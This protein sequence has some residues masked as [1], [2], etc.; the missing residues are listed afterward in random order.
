MSRTTALMLMLILAAGMNPVDAQG[1]GDWGMAAIHPQ[2]ERFELEYVNP[3][4]HKW[5]G[6]RHLLETHVEPWHAVHT[7]YATEL[8]TRYVDRLLEGEM[9]Y[10]TFGNPL[11]RG[12]LV[13]N[14]VQEQPLARGSSI[15]K[16]LGGLSSQRLMGGG[17]AAYRSF[18]NRLVIAS[19]QRGQNSYR[20][21]IGDEIVTRFTPLT[22]DKPRFNGVRL[23]HAAERYRTSLLLSRP[24]QPD[25]KAQSNATHMLG[26]HAEFQVSSQATWGFTY[27]NA[28]NV[29]TQVEFDE[30]N[31]LYGILTTRQNQPLDKLWVRIRD[32]SPGVGEVGVVLAG[33]DIVMVD[34]SGRELRGREIDFLP[35]VEGGLAQGGRL[36]AQN[37]EEILLEYDLGALDYD[38]IQTDDL[39][40]VSVE[41]SVANDYRIEVASDLQTSGEDR[42]PEIVFLPVQRAAG[43]VRDNSNTR[44]VEVD[45]GL[46][47]ASELIGTD[48]NLID[49]NG[50]SVQGELVINRR[51]RRYP[52]PEIHEHHAMTDRAAAGYVNAV[53]D[54][55]PWLLF[56]ELFSIDGDYSTRYWLTDGN[57]RLSYKSPVPQ[58]YEFVDDDDDMNGLTEWQRPY[59]ARWGSDA[60][61]SAT[62]VQS[63]Q[64][65]RA[66][67]GYDE[68]GDGIND[69]NQNRNLIP[70]Y[71]EPFLRYRS[72]RPEFLFGLD[73]NH[74]G[75]VD[76]F[77]NDDFPDYPY[78]A[79]HR[80]FNLYSRIQVVP[81]LNATL[82]R[83]RLRL[84][85]GD[86][87]S[88]SWYALG[89][90][91]HLLR[92]G[93]QLRLF[94][95]GASV[96]DDIPD[97]LRQWAQPIDAPGRMQEVRDL[98]PGRDS[99]EYTLYA[100]LD[101]R[102]GAQ[103]RALHRIKWSRTQQRDKEEIVRARE[104]RPT[105]GF[106]GMINKVEW[107]L[108]VGLAV[109][110]PRWKSEYR[111]DRPF[112]SRLPRAESLEETLFL[113]WSQP[114]LAEQVGVSYFPRYGRQ[115]FDSQI[116]LGLELSRFWLL[117]GEREE[118]DRD[119]WNWT[120]VAQ[121]SNRT[122]YQGYQ[123]VMR[124][125]A[126]FER[127]HF[128]RR[129]PQGESLVFMTVN[130]G[131]RQ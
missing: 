2:G 58:V 89:T 68:N 71:E 44:I 93:G 72:D 107:S 85:S 40:R 115:L 114:L 31:P 23:D 86:G 12:W 42:N 129:S 104:G 119:F 59:F 45:Y 36:V 97:D 43:N 4:L 94:A 62:S 3:S 112:S 76:R 5:Y 81:G 8:Y 10:D 27:V 105:S 83:Q 70:D 28:H 11:G 75:V 1:M 22:F 9:A 47:V 64:R 52:N 19:D 54:F 102:L 101:Q 39:H 7:R 90:W 82:G 124:T 118:A 117:A 108:P 33:F 109:F 91:I 99:W 56:A 37:A 50:L 73:M 88:Q 16:K 38:D 61:A 120:G 106:L 63:T 29:Q 51:H 80:G 25:E 131:L 96:R 87:R 26:G 69:Y 103:I 74:N 111:R 100:D 60:S 65:E 121:L 34:T 78:R 110:E 98:L 116:Q 130:A 18:F 55:F 123:I 113:L 77:E 6:P 32:D 127:R 79:D 13:Y 125:G 92:R 17:Q 49:W 20:L 21:I 57:G 41:L 128:A 30:G 126:Q 24:S 14:W 15:D 48:W 46:P 67:P 95:Y 35:T 66:W 53:F 84:I 122:A